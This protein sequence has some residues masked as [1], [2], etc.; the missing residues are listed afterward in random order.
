MSTFSDLSSSLVDF[1]GIGRLFPLPNLVLFPH[2]MQ[3]LHIFEPRYRELLE[4][5]LAGDRMIV[6]AVLAP[7]WQRNYEGRPKVHSMACLGHITTHCRLA[8]G[9]YNV[10]VLGLQRVRLLRELA[11][12]RSFREAKIKLCEDQYRGGSLRRQRALQQQ[13]RDV[14]VQ[15][16]PTMPEAREQLDQ[17]LGNNVP[18]G[19]LTDVV[20]YLLDIDLARKQ[21][22]LAE[23]NVYRRA[24]LLLTDLSEAAAGLAPSREGPLYFPPQFSAN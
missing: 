22:L 16:L 19:L 20:S 9:T 17:L 18:L 6:M 5:A 3:P 24:D 14:L 8:D 12:A 1:S 4:D 10:L 13:F 15:V 2:V 11:T 21:S 7:G 23:V